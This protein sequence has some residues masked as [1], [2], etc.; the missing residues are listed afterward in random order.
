MDELKYG[1]FLQITAPD[2]DALSKILNRCKGNERTMALFAGDCGVN[3]STLS[4][5]LNGKITKPLSYETLVS[6][7]DHRSGSADISFE[8]LANANGMRSKESREREKGIDLFYNDPWDKIERENEIQK[9]IVNGLL[10]RGEMIQLE[11]NPKRFYSKNPEYRESRWDLYPQID[12]VVNILE[13]GRTREWDFYCYAKSLDDGDGGSRE[14][15]NDT[16]QMKIAFFLQDSWEPQIL[17]GVKSSFLFFEESVFDEFLGQL[18]AARINSEVS[19]ILV[20]YLHGKVVREEWVRDCDKGK[21][22]LFDR[23]ITVED[24]K[25]VMGL[26]TWAGLGRSE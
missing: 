13:G 16:I 11:S 24:G 26:A 12:F 5:I 18:R 19:V 10:L 17:E 3:A 15:A 25:P 22:S 21:K 20:D 8:Q 1:E 9:I 7:Y 6:I 2:K 4:R 23:E 14:L